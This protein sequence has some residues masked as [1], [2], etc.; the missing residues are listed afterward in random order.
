MQK[1]IHYHDYPK[2]VSELADKII[3]SLEE[4][5]FFVKEGASPDVTFKIFA[6]SILPKW[7]NGNMLDIFSDEEFSNILNESIVESRV[8]S[9]CE[10][11]FLDYV[12]DEEG[13]IHYFLTEQAKEA[14][15]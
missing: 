15:K 2:A 11:G 8:I 13:K 3:E 1:S 7:I 10:R 5:N 9:L 14:I 4:D 6:D 12:E